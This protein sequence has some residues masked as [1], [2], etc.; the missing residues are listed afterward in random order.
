MLEFFSQ[1]YYFLDLIVGFGSPL[2][3]YILFRS[4]HIDRMMW[5][6][7]WIG[8]G[9][10]LLWEIPI[11][12][13]SAE[14]EALPLIQW[15]RPLP[16]HYSIFM[17]SH[18]LWDGMLFCIGIWLVERICGRPAFT[19]FKISEL[20]ILLA[21]G[22]VSE[23]FVELSSTMNEGWVYI[24]TYWWNPVMMHFD[25]HS[26]TWLMQSIWGIAPIIF[27][28]ILLKLRSNYH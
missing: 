9:I 6:F 3:F 15:V 24:D 28:I 25:G 19:S 16:L 14:S 8:A 5:H 12:V 20:L 18:S 13:L 10:G 4:R 27:Y 23:L 2:V 11:F 17:V 21:W 26:I 1:S 22:Q 7:F